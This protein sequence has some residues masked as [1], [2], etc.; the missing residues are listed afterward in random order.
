[1]GGLAQIKKARRELPLSVCAQEAL[2]P[3][4]QWLPRNIVIIASL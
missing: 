1:M 3:E 4:A 2:D